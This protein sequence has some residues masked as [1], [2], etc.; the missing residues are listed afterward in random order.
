MT[1]YVTTT[2]GNSQLLMATAIQVVK[3]IV[4]LTSVKLAIG[5]VY[6]VGHQNMNGF[7]E[8]KTIEVEISLVGQVSTII[9]FIH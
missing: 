4:L 9:T 6:S 1:A 3:E 7:M 2:A 8:K 5:G